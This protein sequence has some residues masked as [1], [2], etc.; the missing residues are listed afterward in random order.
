[1]LLAALVWMAALPTAWLAGQMAG[2]PIQMHLSSG[3]RRA[4]MVS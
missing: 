4:W 1:M 2:Q 3:Y